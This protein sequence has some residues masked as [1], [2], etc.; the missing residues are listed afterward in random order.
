MVV[1]PL[2]DGWCLTPFPFNAL[3]VKLY[4]A[5]SIGAESAVCLGENGKK[6]TLMR[7]SAIANRQFGTPEEFTEN[8]PG[9][10]SD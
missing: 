3:F 8:N 2:E 5:R 4:F 7:Q 1:A 9:R 6:L 10:D